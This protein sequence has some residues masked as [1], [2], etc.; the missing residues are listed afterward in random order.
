MQQALADLGFARVDADGLDFY[1][2][3]PRSRLRHGHLDHIEDFDPAVLFESH[4]LRH[5]IS[6]LFDW[7]GAGH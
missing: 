5:G 4:R 2:H 7:P 1:Q 6:V 3:L